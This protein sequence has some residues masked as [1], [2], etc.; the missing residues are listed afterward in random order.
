MPHT[1]EAGYRF[2]NRQG[3]LRGTRGDVLLQLERWL[4]DEQDHHVFWLN[5]LAGTGKST[6]A[7]TFAENSFADGKLGASFFCSRDFEDRSKLQVIFPTIAFQLAYRYPLFREELLQVLKATPGVGRE[8]LCSQMER[9]IVGPLKATRIRTL[10]I[11]DALDECEDEEPASALLSVLSRYVDK[12]PRVKFFI[13]GRP[14]PRIRSGFRLESLRPITEVFRLHDVERSSVDGDIK[15]FFRT[16]LGDIAKT[17]SDC[18]LTEHWPSPSS[19]DILCKKAA[20]LFIYASTVVKFIASRHHNPTKRL[21]LIISLPHSTTHEGKSGIDPL[22]TQ[23]LEQA[24]LDVDSDEQEIYSDFRSVVGAV[25]L[26]FNPLPMK[27]LSTILTTSDISTTLHSLHSVL[28]FPNNKDDP[29]Q[30]FHKSF[31]DFLMDSRR[32]KDNRF[33]INPSVHHQEILLLCLNLMEERLKRNICNLDYYIKLSDV[34]D[35]S[36]CRKEHIGEALEYTCQFWTRHLMK[37]PSSGPGVEKVQKAIEKFFTT[38]LL[39]WIEVLIIIGNL[40]ASVYSIND[41]Q[42]WYTSVS[43]R[44]AIC[45]DIYSYPIQGGSVCKWADDSQNLILEH[46]DTIHNSPSQLY[47]SALPLFPLSW[48]HKYYATE[49]L[50]GPKLIK[51]TEAG[52]G[53]CSRAISLDS[54][55]WAL[56]Y[57]DNTLAAGSDN[58]DIIILNA[59]TGSQIAILSEHHARVNC[60]TFSSDG[61][62]LVSGSDDM[63]VKLWDIQTGGVI[64]TFCGHAKLVSSVSISADCTIIASGSDDNTIHLWD[65]QTQVC[66]CVIEQQGDIDSVSFSPTNPQHII[67]TSCGKVWQWDVKGHQIPPTY[68]GTY[69]SFSP[70]H[71]QFALCNEQ[72][73]TVQSSDSRAIVA[74]FHVANNYARYCCFSPDGRLIAAAADRTAYVWDITNS[75]PYLVETFVGHTDDIT[76]LVF[77]SPSSIISASW[78][79]SV[80]FWKI[81]ALSI[82]PVTA[83]PGL[84]VSTPPSIYSVSLQARA[85]IAISCDAEGMVKT[86]DISTGFCKASFQTPAERY[87]YRDVQ[88][89]DS[90]LVIV[91]YSNDKIHIWDINNGEPLQV[92]D[93]PLSKP[94]SLRI[95][96]DGSKVFYLTNESI[97]AWS[98]CTGE[99]VGKVKLELKQILYLYPLQVDDS[100]IWIQLEDLSTQGWDFGVPG[101]PPIQLSDVSTIRPPLNLIGGPSSETA[102]TY[103][104]KD[105]VTGKEVFQLSGRYAEPGGVQWD[106]QYLVAGYPSGEV[107]ILDFYHMCS[108]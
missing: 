106:G 58:G 40:D 44:Y 89:I 93:A 88:L 63:T 29:I 82:G 86:W 73:I 6:I 24:F 53:R 95:S 47:H 76:A 37:I 54:C 75:D 15:L 87:S 27:V 79:C 12:I 38:H 45:Q 57:C 90:R 59:I 99:L 101:S 2:G 51:G 42:Q 105:T 48:L 65:I 70:D 26:V 91:W 36:T 67:S 96:G 35:L 108:Q 83:N 1:V 17:R 22:Y 100:R 33:F 19:V 28:L 92:I 23:I 30:A 74:E 68:D 97:Q 21:I 8:S 107:L 62:L 102:N 5:G 69:I 80:K 85:G 14:E 56:S 13:T 55:A 3:C 104:I 43:Y 7:Q 11:I 71:A 81:G 50:Q 78:D 64:K 98:I 32:C 84:T 4:K 77:S 20:G 66:L 34:N 41:I 46:F 72:V 103:W 61:K 9:I 49:L 18:D 39:Y 31:P 52:W 60:L 10:I 25:L 94:R 16:R